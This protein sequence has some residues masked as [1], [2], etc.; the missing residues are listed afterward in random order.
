M[1]LLID[2][3]VTLFQTLVKQTGVNLC[4]ALVHSVQLSRQMAVGGPVLGFSCIELLTH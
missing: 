3:C 4:P 1:H 2:R